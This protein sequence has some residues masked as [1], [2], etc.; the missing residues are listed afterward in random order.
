VEYALT[1]HVEGPSDRSSSDI[2]HEIGRQV[3]LADQLGYDA[4]WFAEHHGHAHLGHMP[5]PLLFALYLAARTERI[6]L[7]A[8]V[9]CVNLHHPILV[10]E[11]IATVDALTGGRLSLGVGSGSTAPELALYGAPDMS[12]GVRRARFGEI[13][14]ILEAAWTGQPF[15]H[16]GEHFDIKAPALLPRPERDLRD[17]LWIGANSPD[18][19]E[20]AGQR[21]Y[22][23]Q[24]SNLRTI[25]ELRA[26]IAAYREGRAAATRDIA[27]ERIAASAPCYVAATDEQALADFQP[28]LDDLLRENR[29]TRPVPTDATKV[30]STPREHLTS[31]RFTVGSPARCVDDLLALREQLDFTTLNLRPRWGGQPPQQVESSIELFARAVRPELDRAWAR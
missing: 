18:S 9:V 7:G 13:L 1:Y 14:D 6:K 10:A 28:A 27:D 22:G 11:Q 19:A 21:G 24:L 30:P 3:S 29:R 20:V 4:A 5:H 8:A 25:P 2:F 26:L 31:L 15:H 17:D 16:R 12:P 23:L